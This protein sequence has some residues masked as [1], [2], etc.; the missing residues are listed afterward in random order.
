MSSQMDGQQDGGWAR[1][2]VRAAR[3]GP[4]DPGSPMF[5]YD[6][7]LADLVLSYAHQRLSM[8]PIPIGRAASSRPDP[9]ELGRLLGTGG[10][11]PQL[12][13]DAFFEQVVPPSIPADSPDYLAF[14]AQAP[15]PAA[16]LFDM[17]VSSGSMSASHW[18]EAAGAVTAE[19]QTLRL[20]ADLAGL[21]PQAGGCF[22]SGGSAANL[23]ALIVAR[24]QSEDRGRR[25]RIAVS[26]EAHASIALALKVIAVDA[27]V[28]QADDHRLT[29]AALESAL[30]GDPDPGDVIGVVATAGTTNAGIVDQLDGIADVARARGLWLHVDGAYGAAALFVP[31]CRPLFAGIERADS[32]VIDPH[33][34]LFAPYDCGAVIYREP[35]LARRALTQRASYL[36]TL[37]DTE[38]WNPADY[39]FHLT[40]RPRGLALWFSL[41]VHGTDAY[42]DAIAIG[43]RATRECADLI[44]ELPYLELIRP[45]ELTVVLFRREGWDADD[46]QAWSQRL[47]A[48]GIAFV[49]PTTW[50]GEPTARLAFMHPSTSIELV[51]TILAAMA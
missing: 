49:A 34:W 2:L 50:E 5:A 1:S 30:A 48:E 28:V 16:R 36:D 39:A 40:R 37:T 4:S 29:G 15:T 27:L 19:N 22:V 31:E 3:S 18:F 17:L 20:L 24:E 13:L 26:S 21:P 25:P 45:P 7:Q 8:D 9:E 47:F 51:Q 35:E 43:L 46:Y 33:K 23:S 12:V 38:G 11:D 14:I 41:A 42:R 32:L 44:E 10:N 6:A